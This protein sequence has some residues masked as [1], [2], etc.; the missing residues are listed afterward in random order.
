MKGMLSMRQGAW[1]TPGEDEAE[2]VD[3]AGD[4]EAYKNR[5]GADLGSR[6]C[7]ASEAVAA[8]ASGK[9]EGRPSNMGYKVEGAVASHRYQTQRATRKA[10]QLAAFNVAVVSLWSRATLTSI[11]WLTV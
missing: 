11:R 7:A 4:E 10:C 3:E 9:V 2:A 6:R 8:E 1:P 5:C